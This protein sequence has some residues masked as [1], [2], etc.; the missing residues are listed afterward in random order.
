M[1]TRDF[2]LNLVQSQL[3]QHVQAVEEGLEVIHSKI[4]GLRKLD[5]E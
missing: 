1:I 5:R 3:L 2:D 4:L